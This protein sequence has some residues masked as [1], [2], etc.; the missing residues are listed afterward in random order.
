MEQILEKLFESV[1]KVRILR[2][3]LQNPNESFTIEEIGRRTLAKESDARKEIA[4]L[5]KIGI[6]LQKKDFSRIMSKD[7]STLHGNTRESNLQKSGKE[8]LYGINKDFEVFQELKD[9]ITRTSTTSKKRLLRDLRALGGVKLALIAGLFLGN[10]NG[11]KTDLLIVG[12]NIKRQKINNLLMKVE[13]ELG[14]TLHYTI[15]DTEEFKYRLNMYD[16]FLRDI[17]EYP[18]EK[19]INK[20]TFLEQI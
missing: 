2:L 3:L 4:K 20:F 5:H 15:M 9:L 17:F 16:R 18:H 13:T 12:D 6:V 8:Q 14:K 19:L 7:D 1:P 11:R 10:E